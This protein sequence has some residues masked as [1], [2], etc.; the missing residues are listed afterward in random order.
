MSKSKEGLYG[1]LYLL[2][3]HLRTY[4]TTHYEY[5]LGNVSDNF[6]VL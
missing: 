4:T 6:L 5:V 1:A 2:H 3:L